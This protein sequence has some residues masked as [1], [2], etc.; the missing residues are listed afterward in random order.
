LPRLFVT[1]IIYALLFLGVRQLGLYATSPWRVD[2][3]PIVLRRF[4]VIPASGSIMIPV[5]P[6]QSINIQRG[7]VIYI[8]AEVSPATTTCQWS[9]LYGGALHTAN[10]CATYYSPPLG[11]DYDLLD[12]KLTSLCN[13]QQNINHLSFL[14]HPE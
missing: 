2:E 13:T 4:S 1:V 12:L 3:T 10:Q 5:Q 14:I 11:S 9:S 6:N 7:N 8:S